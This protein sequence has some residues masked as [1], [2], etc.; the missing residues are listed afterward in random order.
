[1]LPVLTEIIHWAV[2]L[3]YWEQAILEKIITEAPF[4][5][6]IYQELYQYLLEDEGLSKQSGKPRPELRFSNDTKVHSET[7]QQKSMVTKI[8]N[9]QN[10]NALAQRQSIPFNSQLTAIYGA[11]ASGKSG[12]ARVLGCAGFT[13]GDRKVF[14]NV[15]EEIG[16]EPKQSADLEICS[17][18]DT[19]N[20]C[21]LVG[22][23]SADL[24]FCHVFDSTSV[25]VHLTKSNEFS[26]SPAGLDILTRLAEETDVVRQLLRDSIADL[27]MPHT[28]SNYFIGDESVVSEAI[29]NLSSETDLNE[30][31]KFATITEEEKKKAIDD[32]EK[33]NFLRSL[34]IDVTIASI[35]KK[36][37][38]L[39]GLKG[40]LAV[41]GE[42]L[43][44]KIFGE[45]NKAI[46]SYV[47]MSSLAKQMGI[48]QFK[49]DYFSQI[50]SNEWYQFIKTGKELAEAETVSP[51]GKPYPQKGDRCL[52]CRQL[53]SEEALDLIRR[54]WQFL[55]NQVQSKLRLAEDALIKYKEGFQT[56][57]TDFFSEESVY[58]RLVQERN[59]QLL[60]VLQNFLSACGRRKSKGIEFIE[61]TKTET[62]EPLPSTGIH[63]LEDI[64]AQL[65]KERDDLLKKD[66]K[67]ETEKLEKSLM[68]YRHRQILETLI[69][70][71]KTYVVGRI[72]ASV[73]S[74]H[75]GS[76]SHI[77][78]KHDALFENIVKEGYVNHFNEILKELGP[79]INVRVDTIPRKS[80]IYK[81]IVLDKCAATVIEATPDKI[82]SDGEKRA[83][84][85]ADFLTEVDI[86]PG[87]TCMVLDDPVTSFDLEWSEKIADI[88]AKEATKRQVIVF[89]HDLAFL[90]HLIEAAEREKIDISCHWIQRGW[91]NDKPGYISIDNSPAIDKSFKKPT[92]AQKFFERAKE[93]L[94]FSER[95]DLL[96]SGFGA[97]RTC[98]EAFVIFDLFNG[99]VERFSERIS[100]GRLE[101]IVWDES[102][103]REIN[104]KYEDLS[105]LMEGHLHSTRFSHKELTPSILY[106]EI[107]QFTELKNRLKELKK[108]K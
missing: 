6:E 13:R 7:P 80:V 92:K 44:D 85:L 108:K 99:V 90:Y 76:T 106:A 58:Y 87:C 30:L 35:N 54:L 70:E 25:N 53:L 96:K 43:T 27:E 95:E 93:E 18:G 49:C 66:P 62:I 89:T 63:G 50:G 32:E 46:D 88:F 3:K 78:R 71:V 68:F 24:S 65:E 86:D 17:D 51:A 36:I 79:H 101:E 75:I 21:Y 102:I 39:Y 34:N 12:Y 82:L 15:A 5:E 8:S 81:Q 72:W 1:M 52:L 37:S 104:N 47:Q 26:Y 33:L 84:S 56:I 2:S 98:Y 23:P 42:Q 38:D 29:K 67:K 107:Q 31:N 45:L 16:A 73:A 64:I 105:L 100:L 61:N 19:E 83:V 40:K 4:T 74:N 60:I 14:P 77:T 11:N 9:L 97:L 28:F 94:N 48:D 10:I 69:P 103:V 55:E 41:V 22:V 59:S 20:I 91:S 57:A